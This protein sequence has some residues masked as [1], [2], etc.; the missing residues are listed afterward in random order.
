MC[1]G[2][3]VRAALL[4]IGLITLQAGAEACKEQQHTYNVAGNSIYA[5]QKSE[6]YQ[7]AG[8]FREVG[9]KL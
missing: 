2:C 3:A 8:G 7:P 9:A 4:S 6:G 5:K 1:V